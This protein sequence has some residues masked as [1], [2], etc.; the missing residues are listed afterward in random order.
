MAT[1]V[2]LADDSD[3]MRSAIVR[4]LK[5]EPGL[6]VV[7]EAA[8]FAETVQLVA[9]VKPDVLLLDLHMPDENEYT[10]QFVKSQ[11][12]QHK[13]CIV[14]ISVWNDSKARALADSFGAKVFL[15]KT[16]LYST[17]IPAIKTCL[18]VP[19]KPLRQRAKKASDP[20]LEASTD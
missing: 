20:T 8:S 1:R 3:I 6:E 5:E 16:T 2:L 12:L 14:A 19:K 18:S 7:G 17:L 15:D 9:T 4:V 11:A 13:V 10:P